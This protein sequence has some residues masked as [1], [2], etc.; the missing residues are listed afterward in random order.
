MIRQNLADERKKIWGVS[1]LGISAESGG[2]EAIARASQARVCSGEIEVLASIGLYGLPARS[3]SNSKPS[4]FR[5][6][7]CSP[8]CTREGA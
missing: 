7:T 5:T 1:V 4:T 6:T 8:R 3:T 2:R